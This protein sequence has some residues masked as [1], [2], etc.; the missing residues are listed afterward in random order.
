MASADDGVSDGHTVEHASPS[1]RSSMLYVLTVV[2]GNRP[3]RR[4]ELAFA[5]FNC[6]EWAA[7]IAMLVYAYA[8]G[9]V[10]ETEIGRASCRERV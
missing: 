5:T 9:G 10:T 3:L 4:V 1:R 8:Q 2:A 7:W 6:G